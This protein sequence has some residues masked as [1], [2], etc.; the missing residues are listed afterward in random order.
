[1]TASNCEDYGNGETVEIP[2]EF[3]C[4][5]TQELMTDPVVTRYGQSYERGSIVEWI[6]KGKDCPLTR[7]PLTLSGIITNH[8]LR[9]QIR[10]WQVK[11]QLDITL[12]VHDPYER[13]GMYGYF[14]IPEKESDDTERTTD[15]E[16]D[17]V[18]EVPAADPTASSPPHRRL[19]R[20]FLRRRSATSRAQ[21]SAR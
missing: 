16:A 17:V 19:R 18:R 1:M 5:I 2:E 15:D 10:R 9:S 14:M 6:S 13:L 21:V 7:Q 12:V 4:P 8:A 11:N 20:F 3:I